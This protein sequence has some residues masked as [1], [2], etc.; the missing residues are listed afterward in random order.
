MHKMFAHCNNL[1]RH[2]TD[3]K[4]FLEFHTSK[5]DKY[6][7][8]TAQLLNINLRMNNNLGNN[9]YLHGASMTKWD[10]SMVEREL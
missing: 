8:D 6:Q 4:C 7:F 5:F 3:L 1:C 9:E 2:T 10:N